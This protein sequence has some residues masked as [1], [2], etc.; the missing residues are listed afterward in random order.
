MNAVNAVQDRIGGIY[1]T[2]RDL[3]FT[4]KL[5]VSQPCT[6]RSKMT[7][8]SISQIRKKSLVAPR[9]AKDLIKSSICSLDFCIFKTDVK[10]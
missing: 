2:K 6:S 10:N 8:N 7:E 3:R 9:L 5:N 1:I 4:C